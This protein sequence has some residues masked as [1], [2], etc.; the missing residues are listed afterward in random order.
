MYEIRWK[1][2]ARK[3]F[4]SLP[5][6][7][8]ESMESRIDALVREPRPPGCRKMTG[9]DALYRIRVGDYR[10]IYEVRDRVLLVIVIWTGHRGAA[11]RTL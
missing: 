5:K 8:R 3:S 1:P 9:Y 6:R 2:S 4:L 7:V 11:Y 10:V